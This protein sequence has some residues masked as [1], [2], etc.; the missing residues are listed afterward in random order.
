M[1]NNVIF[2]STEFLMYISI[3]HVYQIR[4]YIH[5]MDLADGHIAALRKLFTTED[6]GTFL[7][8]MK[9]L[10]PINAHNLFI[11]VAMFLTDVHFIVYI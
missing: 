4:D 10:I 6:I 9:T 2:I 7:S 8:S 5:V 3:L 1:L 11:R